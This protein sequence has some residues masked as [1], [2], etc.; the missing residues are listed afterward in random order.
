[1]CVT[2]FPIF[3]L[4]LMQKFETSISSIGIKFYIPYIFLKFFVKLEKL[5]FCLVVGRKNTVLANSELVKIVEC[6]N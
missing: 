6:L 3:T 2:K 1:M 5:K 4:I